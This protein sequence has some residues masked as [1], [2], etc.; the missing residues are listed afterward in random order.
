M[1]KQMEKYM[2]ENTESFLLYAG[3]TMS[4]DKKIYVMN[5]REYLLGR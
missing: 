2:D 4:Y 5:Y 3:E 1:I